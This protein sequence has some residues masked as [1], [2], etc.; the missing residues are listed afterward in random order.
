MRCRALNAVT[1]IYPTLA[2][3]MVDVKILKIVVEI[4]T[5]S[6]KV[7]AKEGCMGSKD[8]GDVYVAL[9]AQGDGETRLPLVKVG[10]NGRCE[11]PCDVLCSKPSVNRYLGEGGHGVAFLS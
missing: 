10:D 9:A 3:L 6:A 5:S 7:S 11:L 2:C 8:R 1:M 4:D